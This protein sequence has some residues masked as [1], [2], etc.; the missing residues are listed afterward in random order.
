MAP[1]D[2][3]VVGFSDVDARGADGLDAGFDED[4]TDEPD[5][6]GEQAVAA[7]VTAMRPAASHRCD[8]G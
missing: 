5:I 2:G 7:T 3:A 6:A 8:G 1:S 4:P